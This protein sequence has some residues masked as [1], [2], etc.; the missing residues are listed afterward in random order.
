MF[1]NRVPRKIFG[2]EGRGYRE[3]EETT[4]RGVFAL[5]SSSNTSITCVIKSRR[6]GHVGNRRGTYRILMGKTEGKRP[7]GVPWRRGEDNIK[8]YL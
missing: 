6:A 7:L 1:K 8:T 4:Q 3:V 2:R 5:Y